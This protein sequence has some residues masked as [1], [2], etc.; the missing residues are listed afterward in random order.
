MLKATHQGKIK[1]GDSELL[2]A[3]LEDGTRIL[4]STAIFK[5]FNR[6]RRGKGEA[7]GG[8]N[9]PSFLDAKNLQPYINTELFDG[10]NSVE[11]L[12]KTNRPMT[13]YKAEILPLI[14]DVYL[15]ARNAGVLTSSQQPLALSAEMLVRS[16]SK[17]GIA[18]LID[19]A[20]G[21]QA[22]REQD[23]L[24]KLLSMY[25]SEEKLQWAKMFPDEFYRQLFRLKGWSYNPLSVKKPQVVGKL[26]NMLVY[27][28]LPPGVLDELRK[29]NPVKNKQ[30]GRRKATHHQYLS[31]DIGQK[32][33]HDHLMQLIAIMRISK[34]WSEFIHNFEKAFG[35]HVQDEL[36][37]DYDENSPIE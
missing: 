37:F 5:A 35:T 4:S 8:T 24:Q 30:S 7:R 29:L 32:D 13:G 17:V 25:L 28:K 11:Y 20:T 22:D 27:E 18:A 36:D 14:C 33:L 10:T 2:C 26:T 1:I 3:V 34:N 23:S 16:L 12:S 19:E 9:I 15:N 6:P 21:Y 31:A